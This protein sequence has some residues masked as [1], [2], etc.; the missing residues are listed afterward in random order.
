MMVRIHTVILF[1]VLGLLVGCNSKPYDGP[2]VDTFNGRVVR[3]GEPV[4]FPEGETVQM[5]VQL[6]G[7]K[8]VA[9]DIKLESDGSFKIGWMPIGKY[10][11]MLNRGAKGAKGPPTKYNVPGE[12]DIEPGKTEY[13]I[14]LGDGWNP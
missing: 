8:G 6:I 7:G 9:Y 14:E 4:S 5:H 3:K 13:Q 1:A 11:V 12:L 10:A 2:T